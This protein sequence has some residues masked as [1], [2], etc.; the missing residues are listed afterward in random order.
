LADIY[1]MPNRTLLSYIN[2]ANVLEKM[3]EPK[4]EGLTG[5][6]AIDAMKNDPAIRTE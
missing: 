2:A 5:Q 4:K 1:A 3:S 6:A